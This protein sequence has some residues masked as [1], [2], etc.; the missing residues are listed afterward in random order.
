MRKFGGSF[1]E[2]MRARRGL[3][4]R[5]FSGSFLG[6]GARTQGRYSAFSDIFSDL[7]EGRGN[8]GGSY[9]FYSAGPQSGSHPRHY[10]SASSGYD[11]GYV[12]QAQDIESDVTVGL[13]ISKKRAKEGG[14]VTFKT[15]EGKMISVKIPAGVREGQ[16]L[17][18]ARQGR[19][20][21]ACHHPG[22]LILKIK[23]GE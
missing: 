9:Q 5:S 14:E 23:V 3:I 8:G 13:K 21:P 2:I 6:R 16:K 7:L 17:R 1:Q 15:H 22:D 19:E 4:L 12:G 10:Q 20:C 18:L 11:D